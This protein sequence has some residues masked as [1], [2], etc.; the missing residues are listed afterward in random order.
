MK[1]SLS[2]DWFDADTIARETNT[3]TISRKEM[4]QI[5]LIACSLQES[6]SVAVEA[7]ISVIQTK[8]LERNLSIRIQI[9]EIGQM[10]VLVV[11]K[12]N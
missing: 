4:M 2:L 6:I 1:M 7:I 8:K 9:Q 3:T 5:V 10:Y 12:N 11:Q